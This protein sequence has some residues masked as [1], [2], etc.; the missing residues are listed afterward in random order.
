VPS[1][2]SQLPV[3]STTIV[4]MFAIIDIHVLPRPPYQLP[5]ASTATTANTLNM[6]IVM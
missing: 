1:I 4:M 6:R 2:N 3:M 5:S